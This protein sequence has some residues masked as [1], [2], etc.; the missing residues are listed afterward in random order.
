MPPKK[1]DKLDTSEYF[2]E[3]VAHAFYRDTVLKKY[4]AMWV[5]HAQEILKTDFSS[6]LIDQRSNDEDISFEGSSDSLNTNEH[7]S[8]TAALL[9]PLPPTI[10]VVDH[11]KE[12]IRKR[13]ML[14]HSRRQKQLCTKELKQVFVV[15]KFRY[16]CK[17]SKL[18]R[19]CRVWYC[20]IQFEKDLSS[21]FFRRKLYGKIFMAWHSMIGNEIDDRNESDEHDDLSE[22]LTKQPEPKSDPG[23]LELY[24]R[25]KKAIGYGR[26]MHS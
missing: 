6:V 22:E 17:M 13:K 9:E 23:Y 2:F 8:S 4:F 24:R 26:S 25:K 7:F 1:L 5:I 15:A 18:K 16:R 12:K 10:F 20:R 19:L 21:R 3:T 14:E 11:R